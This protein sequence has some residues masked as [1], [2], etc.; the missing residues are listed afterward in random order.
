MVGTLVAS[1]LT[2]IPCAAAEV[3]QDARTVRISE[4]FD[5]HLAYQAATGATWVVKQLPGV[6][7]IGQERSAQGE[8]PGS[9]RR[10]TFHLMAREGGD[11]LL[12]W[13]LIGGG[14][15]VYE[16]YRLQLRVIE[17]S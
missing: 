13:N 4:R 11:H 8:M 15:E 12:E 14:Q 10:I 3:R 16:I 6:A 2:S 17:G 7:L 1:L 9:A 5:V